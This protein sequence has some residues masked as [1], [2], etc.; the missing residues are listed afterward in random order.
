VDRGD[1]ELVFT[2]AEDQPQRRNLV[3]VEGEGREI[4]VE[5][6]GL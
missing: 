2:E 4:V 6:V 5:A 3:V 1:V